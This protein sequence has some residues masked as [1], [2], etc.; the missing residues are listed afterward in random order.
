MTTPTPREVGLDRRTIVTVA[1]LA[2][3]TVVLI[4]LSVGTGD[5][6]MTPADVVRTLAGNGT[7][8]QYL[9]VT[10][11]LPRVLVAV[12]VGAALALAGAVFQTLTRNPL[13][14]PDIIGF[15]TG[16][17]T[18][19][20]A[21]ILLVG[22]TP[23]VVAL[24]ALG[25]GLLT[26]VVIMALCAPHGLSSS[27][28]VLLGV[29]V[30][31]VLAGVN[32]YLLVKASKE[33]AARATVWLVGDLAGRDWHYLVPL[34]VALAILVPAVLVNG[35]ALRMLEMGDEIATGVGVA[36]GRVRVLLLVL[37]VALVAAATAAA[38]PVPFIALIAPQVARRL[39]R[40]PGPNLVAS[41]FVGAALVVAADYLG[42]RVLSS[43][44]LPVG[45]VAATLGGV[46]LVFLLLV[47]RRRGA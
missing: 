45:V 35:R 28:V 12:L 10:G 20:I 3:V 26:T 43:S 7:K 21:M 46:Y 27:R 14:S 19:G 15:T 16:S 13:G 44:L 41:V 32:S 33:N 2:A 22:S 23:S 34:A 38:G 6:P 4:V 5:Y 17:A 24:G 47:G 39:T 42:Q 40:L 29:A 37:A 18:G 8:A 31:A 30:S 25:G 36:V 9:V 11:R 1:I